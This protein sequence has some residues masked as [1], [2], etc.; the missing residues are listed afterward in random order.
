VTTADLPAPV[1][2]APGPAESTH[3]DVAA[4]ERDL[5]AE[6]DGEARFDARGA[7][8]TDA[9]NFRQVP[10]GGTSLAGECTNAADVIDWSK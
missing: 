6:A 4:L 9:S 8:L 3:A 10:I 5:R 7:Y 2:R 1:V